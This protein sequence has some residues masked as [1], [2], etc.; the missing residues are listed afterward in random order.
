LLS[1]FTNFENKTGNFRL[2]GN[3]KF[4]SFNLHLFSDSDP[5]DVLMSV[6]DMKK[7]TYKAGDKIKVITGIYISIYLSISLF[8]SLSIYLFIYLS[9]S[10]SLYLSISIYISLYLLIYLCIYLP[11]SIYPFIQGH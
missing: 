8:L 3:L 4:R 5:E 10:L 9:I 11:M 7:V 1:I 6:A 2:E